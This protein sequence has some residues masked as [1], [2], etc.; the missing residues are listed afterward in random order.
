[1]TG[2]KRS[3]GG[4]GGHGGGGTE[5]WLLTYADLITL[6]M[7]FFIVMYAMSQLDQKKYS[8]MARGLAV[9]LGGGNLVVDTGMGTG[10][11]VSVPMPKDLQAMID[12]AQPPAQ[13][14][15]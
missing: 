4:G 14:Q 1:M 2:R 15:G 3:H 6:M 7:V 12:Q 11:G 5:R 9:A 13:A 8:A 10:D